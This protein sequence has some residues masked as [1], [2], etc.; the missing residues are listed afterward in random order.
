MRKEK[1]ICFTIKY[2]RISFDFREKE[3]IHQYIE[4]LDKQWTKLTTLKYRLSLK[5]LKLSEYKHKTG[6]DSLID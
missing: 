3:F 2:S 1:F 5:A 4:K 6:D